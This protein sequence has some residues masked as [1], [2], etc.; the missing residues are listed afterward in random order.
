M[1]LPSPLGRSSGQRLNLRI[2]AAAICIALI[3]GAINLL[4]PLELVASITRSKLRSHPPSGQLVV[5]TID[6]QSVAAF[7]PPPWPRELYGKLIR[8]LHATGARRIGVDAPAWGPGTPAGDADFERAVAD[9]KG[10]VVLPVRISRD[11]M[12]GRSSVELPPA[13]LRRLVDVGSTNV[14]V[15]WDGMVSYSPYQFRTAD[16]TVPSMASAM[17]Q[18]NGLA[19]DDFPIDFAVDLHALPVISAGDILND[20]WNAKRVAGK[21]VLIGE[22]VNTPRFGAPGY[23][24]QPIVYIHAAAIESLQEGT[25]RDLGWFFP[26]ALAA[27]SAGLYLFQKRRT[28]RPGTSMSRSC[29]H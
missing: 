13:R 6:D 28:G 17:T 27:L 16:L 23:G 7:G 3:C 4:G 5:V 11:P 2:L 14:V 15:R 9:A 19:D 22:T 1:R 10:S 20:R 12:S 8:K 29:R 18:R 21:D 25:P 26:T 24:T